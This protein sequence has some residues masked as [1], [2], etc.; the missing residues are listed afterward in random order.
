MIARTRGRGATVAA[1][2]AVAALALG[3]LAL[4]RGPGGSDPVR[5]GGPNGVTSEV[6]LEVT[7][8]E[9]HLLDLEWFVTGN[10]PGA[11]RGVETNH[12]IT[13]ET[14]NCPGSAQLSA[15]SRSHSGSFVC[16]I[17]ADDAVVAQDRAQA[18]EGDD[19]CF[20]A[21]KLVRP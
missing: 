21:V 3:A 8:L 9:P 11:Q 19:E 6:D 13:V 7:S 14:A 4:Q 2:G 16:R 20:V 1:A 15:R 5:C 10:E 18:D 17:R 12:W